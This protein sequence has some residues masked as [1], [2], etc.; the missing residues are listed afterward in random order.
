MKEK[1]NLNSIPD[2][3]DFSPEKF[4]IEAIGSIR[5]IDNLSDLL[6]TLTRRLKG[7]PYIREL[8]I[9]L[10]N[11]N[12]FEFELRDLSSNEFR[13]KFELYFDSLVEDEVI[14][15]AVNL[16]KS[17]LVEFEDSGFYRFLVVPIANRNGAY[18]IILAGCDN[19]EEKE[20]R[21][22]AKACELIAGIAAEKSDYFYK[23][24]D[25]KK[26]KE[27]LEQKIAVRTMDIAHS[28]RELQSIFNSV[29]TGILVIDTETRKIVNANPVA[30]RTI[31]DSL[32]GIVGKDGSFYFDVFGAGKR[33]YDPN[34]KFSR[35][36]EGNLIKANG[37]IVPVLR[38]VSTINLGPRKFRI[39]SFLDISERKQAETALKKTN[40][41]LELKVRERTVDLR[42][43]VHKLKNEIDERKNAE[44]KMRMLLEREKELSDLKTRFVSMV[45][46]EFRTP[47][48]IIRSSAQ[49]IDKF[50]DGLSDV[51]RSEYLARILK[52]VDNMTDMLE[53]VIFIGKSDA[54][55]IQ[56]RRESL[57]LPDFCSSIIKDFKVGLEID[58]NI[59][60]RNLASE[61]V[62]NLDERLMR[63]MLFN[64]LSN[65]VK[66]SE[67]DKHIELEIKNDGE[68]VEF[69]ITDYGIGIP[70]DEV[71]DI[72]EL[73]RRGRNV[74][75]ISGT[76]LGMS[77]VYRAVKLHGG[78]IDVQTKVNRGTAFIVRIPKIE[79]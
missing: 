45:S 23:T 33:D 36:F 5:R 78:S 60:L 53:N 4:A 50:M 55:K 51:E 35:N 65:A 15:E 40:E 9:F 21:S 46:H 75:S 57:N 52:T 28:K 29:Q 20:L 77:V 48:T 63:Q 66:Y 69:K 72:F 34:V 61:N 67:N 59:V 19:A 30:I 22:T 64:L 10:L 13:D 71:E 76:G 6:D 32:D 24:A 70:E 49:M 68:F 39:E 27:L 25:L 38:S 58:R 3:T 16:E 79:L 41:M 14:G 44:N 26:T 7:L 54:Q 11:R 56:F 1:N 37:A 2:P 47:L 62:A 8:S 73:F 17:S 12:T 42:L 43:L 18:G 31:G 74:G